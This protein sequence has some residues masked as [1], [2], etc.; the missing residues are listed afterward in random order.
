MDKK[1]F[2]LNVPIGTRIIS[3]RGDFVVEEVPDDA[4]DFFQRGSQWLSL[5]PEAVEGLSKLSETKLK[6]LLALKER[7]DMT[8]DAV[9]I[10][11]ALGQILLT[12][13]ETAE[14]KSKSQKKQ[15]A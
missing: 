4:F 10:Q 6:S 12:R 15:E 8:E 5:E 13:T 7:Q 3:S 11:E 1:Y 2:K 9:I 14:D